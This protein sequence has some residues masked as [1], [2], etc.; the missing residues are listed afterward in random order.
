MAPST[1]GECA[2][3]AGLLE[4][5]VEAKDLVRAHLMEHIYTPHAVLTFSIA[6]DTIAFPARVTGREALT[7][8]LVVDFAERFD[9]CRTY[10]VTPTRPS[11]QHVTPA[12]QS[13]VSLPWLVLMRETA[14][15]SMRIGKGFYRWSFALE[16]L[17]RVE[18]MHIHIER[19]DPIAD[20]DSRL[21]RTAQSRL[22]YPWLTPAILRDD[23]AHHV[24][25][26]A[27]L[28]FLQDFEQPI[29]VPM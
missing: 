11:T 9:S 24:E 18:A 21:L 12:M 5:Y 28:A 3:V 8:T 15:A 27:A 29:P 16:P 22:P 23:F 2:S 7:Q 10:Y 26:D 13:T 17:L 6:T 4:R 25:S 14:T 20:P 1:E 19:M